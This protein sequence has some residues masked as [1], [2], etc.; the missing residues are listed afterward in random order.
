MFSVEIHPYAQG[1][2]VEVCFVAAQPVFVVEGVSDG[3]TDAEWAEFEGFE[4]VVVPS[5]VK[6]TDVMMPSSMTSFFIVAS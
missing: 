1:I 3:A 4:G 2:E 6:V 5:C